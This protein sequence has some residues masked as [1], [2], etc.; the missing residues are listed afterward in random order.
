MTY[1]FVTK[2]PKVISHVRPDLAPSH[3]H[4]F[5]VVKQNLGCH[6]II[7]YHEMGRIVIR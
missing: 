4:L 5:L 7:R 1:N 6:K 3:Y 2:I